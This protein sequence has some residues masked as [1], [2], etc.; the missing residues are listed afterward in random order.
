M[1]NLSEES[2]DLLRDMKQSEAWRIYEELQKEQIDTLRVL[3]TRQTTTLEDRLWYSAMAQGREDS[4]INLND[5][6]YD[7]RP[8]SD[9]GTP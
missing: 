4:I 1:S 9:S 6:L 5:I 7:S 2:K 8:K 3:A